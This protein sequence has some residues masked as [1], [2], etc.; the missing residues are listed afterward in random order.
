MWDQY[1]ASAALPAQ[2]SDLALRDDAGSRQAVDRLKA[3]LRSAHWLAEETFAG[4][5]GDRAGKRVTVFGTTGFRF[6][7]DDDLKSE[8]ERLTDRY[9]IRDVEQFDTGARGEYLR[10]G[11][12]RDG[13]ATVAVCGWADHGSLATAVFTRRSPTDSADLLQSLRTTIITR[14]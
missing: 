1:P 10:C 3:D 5:Y 2:V 7:P 12:G 4:V 14:D 6:S 11:V 9:R 13:D 8:L